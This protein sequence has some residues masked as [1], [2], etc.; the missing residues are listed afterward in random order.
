MVPGRPEGQQPRRGFLRSC[1]WPQASRDHCAVGTGHAW[2]TQGPEG[3]G[4][5]TPV[6]PSPR[7]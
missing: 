7:D 1:D 3:R 2:V 4:A 6:F 5:S